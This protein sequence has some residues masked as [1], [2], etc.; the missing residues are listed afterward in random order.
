MVCTFLSKHKVFKKQFTNPLFTQVIEYIKD[1]EHVDEIEEGVRN[2]IFSNFIQMKFFLKD[3][4]KMKSLVKVQKK[5]GST[6]ERMM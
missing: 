2:E 1:G 6:L 4:Q 5:R 3:K